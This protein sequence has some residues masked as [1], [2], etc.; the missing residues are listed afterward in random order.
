MLESGA[1]SPEYLSYMSRDSVNLDDAGNFSVDVL[2]RALS[3]LG[4]SLDI[5]RRQELNGTV[6]SYLFISSVYRNLS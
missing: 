4:L 6:I 2:R 3:S 1:D 5:V